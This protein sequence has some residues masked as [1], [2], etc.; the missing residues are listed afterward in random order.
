MRR[1]DPCA[2][3]FSSSR[4]DCPG[5]KCPAVTVLCSTKSTLPTS[6]MLYNTIII[7]VKC[8]TNAG[9]IYFRGAEEH[10]SVMAGERSTSVNNAF[11]S[12]FSL[13]LISFIVHREA[14]KN[15]SVNGVPDTLPP[16]RMEVKK[17]FALN[18]KTL[19]SYLFMD[20]GGTPF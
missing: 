18:G 1:G 19:R 10:S 20:M 8:G 11:T 9:E 4:L 12:C 7:K 5:S 6:A 17:N 2:S 14:F 3:Q 16:L 13:M 15:P